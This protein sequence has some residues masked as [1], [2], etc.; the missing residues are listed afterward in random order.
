MAEKHN[1]V[2]H[3]GQTRSHSCH[4]PGCERQVKPAMWGCYGHWKRLPARIR[5]DLWEAYKPGQ[6]EGAA[7]ISPEYLVAAENARKWIL[8]T[9]RPG[10]AGK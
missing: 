8:S 5:A 6:E 10:E 9:L 7:Q 1:H 4:W 2:R 3:A